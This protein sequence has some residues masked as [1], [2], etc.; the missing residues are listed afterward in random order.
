[1][2]NM[3]GGS[4]LA[5]TLCTKAPPPT[6]ISKLSLS[7]NDNVAPRWQ[8]SSREIMVECCC[9]RHIVK[10]HFQTSS[11]RERIHVHA[12]RSYGTNCDEQQQRDRGRKRERKLNTGKRRDGRYLVLFPLRYC[13]ATP[14]LRHDVPLLYASCSDLLKTSCAWCL[15]AVTILLRGEETRWGGGEREREGVEPLTSHGCPLLPPGSWRTRRKQEK[16]GRK[17]EEEKKS[18]SCW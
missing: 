18:A 8:L 1:M 12:L 2:F 13:T 5:H 7:N 3:Y 15:H 9:E 10:Q 17:E 14:P 11:Y 16:T 4:Y 6:N